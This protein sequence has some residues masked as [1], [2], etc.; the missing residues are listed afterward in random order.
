MIHVDTF[1]YADIVTSDANGTS[2]LSMLGLPMDGKP[3]F[4]VGPLPTIRF[5]RDRLVL[6]TGHVG[7]SDRKWASRCV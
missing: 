7:A 1:H 5:F 4:F 3:P 6:V 2:D